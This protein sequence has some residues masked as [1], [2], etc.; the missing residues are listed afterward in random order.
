MHSLGKA[1]VM[2]LGL[3]AS[4]RALEAVILADTNRDGKL[5][6]TSDAEGK[7]A[8]A[9]GRGALF[10]ANI[11][12]TDGRCSGQITD[13]TPF[14]DLDKCNDASD[15]ILRNPKF[16]APLQTLPNSGLTDA[17]QGFITVSGDDL[18]KD[19]VRIF[20]KAGNDWA[21]VDESHVFQAAELRAGLELGIDARDVRRPGGWDGRARVHFNVTDNGESAADNVQLR[22]APVLIHH[23]LQELQ[24]VYIASIKDHSKG[25]KQFIEN[26]E[27]YAADA[28]APVAKFD[29]GKDTWAQDNFEAGYTSIPGPDGPVVLRVLVRASQT[30]D[31][32]VSGRNVYKQLRS[33]SVAVVQHLPSELNDRNWNID[34]L[35]NLETVPPHSHKGKHYPNG[36]AVMGS[37]GGKKPHMVAFLE[38]QEAQPPI[39]VDTDWLRVGHT[40][41]FMQFL[42]ANNNRG[43]VMVVDDPKLALDLFKKAQED[44]HGATEAMSRPQMLHDIEFLSWSTQFSCLPSDT[45]DGVL[46]RWKMQERNLLAAERIEANIEIMKRE[47]GITDDDIVRI[48]ALYYVYE[49]GWDCNRKQQAQEKEHH[50]R[51]ER[52]EGLMPAFGEEEDGEEAR[53]LD[54]RQFEKP[55]DK[56]VAYHPAVINGV[57]FN[58]G[59]YLAPNPWG[60]V[61]DGADILAAA[62]NKEYAKYGFNIT[63]IDDWFD[64]HAHA[65]EVHCATNVARDASQKWW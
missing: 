44:G 24:Q 58:D 48:P 61:V 20:H 19:K 21:Y 27:K 33:A 36:R 42:P 30:R 1:A 53:L 5:D 2:A 14:A 10:M 39:E 35:G 56:L 34:S 31:R 3:A 50:K 51:S 23:H 32:E 60:P 54:R 57:V 46:R 45:I 13:D 49:K 4:S 52:Q 63:Y 37:K 6:V 25:T 55:E 17:A 62:A 29:T 40:D 47:T 18:A 64:H 26:V 28:G 22:V 11:A 65:G 59:K 7:Q 15:N 12:D 16:L 43:W 41:E 8:W 9:E 38:A